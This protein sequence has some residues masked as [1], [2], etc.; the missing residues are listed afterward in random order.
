MTRCFIL[1]CCVMTTACS[2]GPPPAAVDAPRFVVKQVHRSDPSCTQPASEC[3]H[4]DFSWP[5]FEEATPVSEALNT[6][7]RQFIATADAAKTDVPSPEQVADGLLTEYLGFKQ[8]FP[9]SR[10]PYIVERAVTVLY[11]SDHVVTLKGLDASYTGGAHG[12]EAVSLASLDRIS[13]KLL[14][15][16]DLFG[17]TPARALLDVVEKRFRAARNVPAGLSLSDAGF[18]FDNDQFRLPKI[19]GLGQDGVEFHFNAYEVAPYSMG[20]T[21]FVVPYAEIGSFIAQPYAP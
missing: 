14:S 17:P 13:G 11:A 1:L 21:S 2:S 4:I 12:N 15:V 16:T 5:Q 10:L 6:W 18:A 3:T 9:D 19:V 20:P 7:S 8:R